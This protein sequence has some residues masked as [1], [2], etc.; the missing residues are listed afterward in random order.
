M[1]AGAE[2]RRRQ[3]QGAAGRPPRDRRSPSPTWE[4]TGGLPRP[5]LHFIRP[6][7]ARAAAADPGAGWAQGQEVTAAVAARG[8]ATRSAQA[9]LARR[10]PARAA[11]VPG[12]GTRPLAPGCGGSSSAA[13]GAGRLVRRRGYAAALRSAAVRTLAGARDGAAALSQPGPRRLKKL[14]LRL[15]CREAG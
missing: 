9:P 15:S 3:R 1:T 14:L 4:R 11:Q 7:P 2:R 12:G 6:C 8:R 5:E 13:E 10:S